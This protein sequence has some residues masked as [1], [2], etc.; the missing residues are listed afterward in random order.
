M[1]F[2][3]QTSKR[4]ASIFRQSLRF[5]EVA[6]QVFVQRIPLR[7]LRRLHDNDAASADDP[8]VAAL[9]SLDTTF[10]EC[11]PC[12]WRFSRGRPSLVLLKKGER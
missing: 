1:A 12:A 8:V 10:A 11:S 9:R 3:D 5:Q 6:A 7:Y 4:K 2:R